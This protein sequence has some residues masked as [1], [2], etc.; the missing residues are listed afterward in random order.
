MN[1]ARQQQLHYRT[2]H[3]VYALI[4]KELGKVVYI[5]YTQNPRK[6]ML[7]HLTHAF[8]VGKN[9]RVKRALSQHRFTPRANYFSFR[10]LWKGHCTVHQ[11]TAI[12]QY[13]IDKFCTSI[14]K[15][16]SFDADI[17][18][19]GDPFQLNVLPSCTSPSLLEWATYYIERQ[20]TNPFN[21]S[22]SHVQDKIE[23]AKLAAEL[24]KEQI[25]VFERMN[26]CK[27]NEEL[28]ESECNAKKRR[29]EV[30]TEIATFKSA[31]KMADD[32]KQQDLCDALKLMIA[33]KIGF[34]GYLC[35]QD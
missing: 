8:Q 18:S 22:V 13:Y 3:V 27:R 24:H 35:E 29:I 9:T 25:A 7:Q 11:A 19:G 33:E 34:S 2:S 28:K 12:E 6:R 16:P 21:S 26:E 14:G 32:L 10:I 1:T 15:R 20:N 4:F 30:D 31:F 17:T 5:G 23:R